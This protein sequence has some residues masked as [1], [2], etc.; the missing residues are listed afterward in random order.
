MPQKGEDFNIE[1]NDVS[2]Y[3]GTAVA[4]IMD[5]LTDAMAWL[6]DRPGG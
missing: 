6:E 1:K 3:E 5:M 2:L 4:N